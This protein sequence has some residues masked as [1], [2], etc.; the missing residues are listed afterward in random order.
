MTSAP[1][2]YASLRIR[3]ATAA[4]SERLIALVN[5]AFSTETFL[6]GTRT[7]EA[8]L[9][10]SMEKGSLLAA[11]D[12]SGRLLASVYV[13]VRG[14]RGYLGML[15][16]DPAHQGG[17]LARRIVAAAEDRLRQQG[18]EG[19]DIGVLS[20]RP[21]LLPIYRRFGYVETGTEPFHF[22]RTFKEDVPCHCI[23]MSKAL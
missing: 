17:G 6:E 16:V 11:E 14:R 5:A 1:L 8:R 2:S 23:L 9:A 13:E 15:A 10:A 18:C 12:G 22:P 7:D 20:L 21:E 4:D 3:E 19:V